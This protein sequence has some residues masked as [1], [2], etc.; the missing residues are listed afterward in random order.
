MNSCSSEQE[1]MVGSCE[2]SNECMGSIKCREFLEWLKNYW[3][4]N[5]YSAPRA[6]WLGG[7]FSQ[8][9]SQSTRWLVSWSVGWLVN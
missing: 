3:F 4:I 2:H 6:S 7:S 1:Q 9:V 5:Q 8:S